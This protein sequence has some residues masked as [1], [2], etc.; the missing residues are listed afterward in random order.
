M[1][2]LIEVTQYLRFYGI[3]FHINVENME[4]SYARRY[5]ETMAFLHQ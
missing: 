2:G 1:I 5:A 4:C 3:F